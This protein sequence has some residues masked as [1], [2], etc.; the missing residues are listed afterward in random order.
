MLHAQISSGAST[1]ALP[2]PAA[3]CTLGM[4]RL[5]HLVGCALAVTLLFAGC[6]DSDSKAKEVDAGDTR[7]SGGSE[8]ALSLDANTGDVDA[9]GSQDAEVPG[10]SGVEN[11]VTACESFLMTNCSTP[12]A[13]FCASAQQ[14]CQARYDTH[15]NCRV[16]LEAMDACAATKPIGNFSCPLGTIPDEVRPYRLTEDVCLSEANALTNCL[17]S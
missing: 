8:D 7:D 14:N 5:F 4:R 3:L 11:C 15:A 9:G 13:N 12:A 16:E 17:D 10:G 1:D 2:R 6:D